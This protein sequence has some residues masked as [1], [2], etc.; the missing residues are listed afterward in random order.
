M[1]ELQHVNVKIFAKPGSSAPWHEMVPVFHKWIQQQ[2]MPELLID[3]ADYA[4]VPAGPGIMLIGHEAFYSLDNRAHRLGFLYN[5]RAA[6]EGSVEDK[7]R[8]AWE[9]A[10]F[11]AQ[12]LAS[13]L[14]G[15][16]EFD[17]N[18]VEVFVN[19][20]LLAPNTNE[21]FEALAPVLRS[22]F[23]ENASLTWDRDRRGLFRVHVKRGL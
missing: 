16:V 1:N 12:R 22:V 13:D 19:D 23:G 17:E 7:L 8:Q 3:V 14:N 4:H 5:R 21:T 6:A 2:A 20:R 9:S 10:Q 18:E 11:G 15:A